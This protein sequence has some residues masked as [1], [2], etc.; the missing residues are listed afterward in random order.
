M[1]AKARRVALATVTA[2]LIGSVAVPAS[3][4]PDTLKRSLENILF[5]P[6]DLILSPVTA[7]WAI[8]QNIRNIDDSPGVRVAYLLPGYAWTTGVQ[9][10]C[11]RT[12]KSVS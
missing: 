9:S 7:G 2:L 4:S 1:T 12:C 8:N 6:L 5:S 11:L 3:A 10:W